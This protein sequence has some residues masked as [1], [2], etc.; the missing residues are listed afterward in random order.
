MVRVSG[1]EKAA[2]H[3]TTGQQV[4]TWSPGVDEVW[5]APRLK[6]VRAAALMLVDSHLWVAGAAASLTLFAARFLG[7]PF[8]PQCVLLVFAATLVI[9][10]ADGH[11]D[12][13]RSRRSAVTGAGGGPACAG[14]FP[15]AGAAAR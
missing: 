10:S 9:Y 2:Q 12:G 3:V 13:Q 1:G 14:G 6:Q 5:R 7:L 15:P 8:Q 4:S 11:F